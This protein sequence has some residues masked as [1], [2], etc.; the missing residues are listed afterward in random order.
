MK[1]EVYEEVFQQLKKSQGSIVSEIKPT[2]PLLISVPDSYF[3]KDIKIMVFGQETNDW[4][5]DF[6][7]E[8][9]VKSLLEIYDKFLTS[10]SYGKAFFNAVSKLEDRVEK[11]YDG[12]SVGLIW[13]NIVKIG[14]SKGKGLPPE[15]IIQWQ[16]PMIE[17]IKLEIQYY[18]PDIV[19]F[20]TGPNY[21]RHIVNAFNATFAAVPGRSERQL[22]KVKSSYLPAKTIRT[23]HPNYLWRNSFYDYL[24]DIIKEV[25]D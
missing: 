8:G 1:I 17:I 13:N 24:D 6:S 9:G 7:C 12:K 20:F 16:S 19:I 11:E 18:Q 21:D 25:Q 14:R 10:R 4:V 23:Y 22:A 2:N 15:D 3:D 5:G